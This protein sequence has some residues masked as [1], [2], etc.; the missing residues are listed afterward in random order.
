[1]S[2]KQKLAWP[3]LGLFCIL[4]TVLACA[5]AT[6]LDAVLEKQTDG[7][8]ALGDV[9]GS[10]WNGSAFIGV[11]ASRN[12]DLAPLLP[13]RFTWHLSPIL[14]L[15]QIELTL[16]NAASLQDKVVLSGNFHH[17][18]VNPG[19][20]ILPS[21]RLS[22][23][24]APLNTIR[25]SGKIILSWDALDIAWPGNLPDINGTMQLTMQDMASA[26]S[27]I[28]PLGSYSMTFVWHGQTADIALK[29]IHGP[30]LLSGKGLLAQGRVQFSGQA[31]AQDGEEDKLA[32]LLNL[33][34]RRQAGADKNVIALEF[35]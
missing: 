17:V 3:A 27:P 14:L 1:M 24:G 2:M 23:L 29:T 26:L 8:F 12:G 32:N 6:W 16:E 33:L 31:E 19:G 10:V 18:Q 34:G 20:V 5:P 35:K 21:E 15:G 25:P 7:R 13:G 9:Q 30:M 28:K 11:A 22:G 4:V